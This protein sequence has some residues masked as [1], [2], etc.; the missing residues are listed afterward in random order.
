MNASMRACVC[1]CT[2]H[3]R[4]LLI[5]LF[6]VTS[7]PLDYGLFGHEMQTAMND[8]TGNDKKLRNTLQLI[9]L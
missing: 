3:T 9:Q 1:G 7:N 2:V 6:F 8:T 5:I 4:L